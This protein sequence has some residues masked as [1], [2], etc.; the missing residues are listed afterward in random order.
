MKLHVLLAFCDIFRNF[1]IFPGNR[2]AVLKARQATHTFR[3]QKLGFLH[4]PP[5]GKVLSARR[6]KLA[7][8]LL[9]GFWV[10]L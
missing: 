8:P 10:F 5:G 7:C 3:T 9:T 1:W 4:A 6:Y 2:L